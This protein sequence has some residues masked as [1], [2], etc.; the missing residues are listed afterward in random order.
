MAENVNILPTGTL[1]TEE[2]DVVCGMMVIFLKCVDKYIRLLE[3]HYHAEYRASKEY[4]VLVERV[5]KIEAERIVGYTVRKIVRGDK[6]NK[7]GRLLK[8]A[9]DFHNTIELL[10]NNAMHFHRE[11]VSDIDAFDGMQWDMNWLCYLYALIANCEEE[12]DSIR[13]I[14][15]VKAMAKGHLV[16][17]KLLEKLK[18][19]Y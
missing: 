11:G 8:I 17:D 19:N 12:K 13:I 18:V 14:S 7:I 15:T 16:S 4:K 3:N 5:G 9:E 1:T 6:R 2:Q 10:E